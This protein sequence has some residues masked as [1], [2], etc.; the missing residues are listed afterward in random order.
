MVYIFYLF[1]LIYLVVFIQLLVRMDEMSYIYSFINGN[2][3]LFIASI[4]N[5][6]ILS[7]NIIVNNRMIYTFEIITRVSNIS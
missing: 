1:L 3:A 7:H 2:T 6:N 4:K 5:Q